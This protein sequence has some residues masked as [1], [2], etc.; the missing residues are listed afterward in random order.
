MANLFDFDFSAEN[1]AAATTTVTAAET[2]AAPGLSRMRVNNIREI[3]ATMPKREPAP[4]KPS[5]MQQ[6]IKTFQADSDDLA[7]A[8]AKKDEEIKEMLRAERV[9]E[10]RD[11][12]EAAYE[13][14]RLDDYFDLMDK[15]ERLEAG[16]DEEPAPEMAFPEPKKKPEPSL[17]P[18]EEPESD[19][20]MDFMAQEIVIGINKVSER[21]GQALSS[22]HAEKILRESW[23]TAEINFRESFKALY[24]NNQNEVIGIITV[25]MGGLTS[26]QV[27][28]KILFAGALKV[29]ATG[30]IVAHNHPSGTLHPSSDDKKITTKI[31]DA[32]KLLDI[33]ILDHMIITESKMFSFL[34][35]GLM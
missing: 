1:A 14:N 13:E 30:I 16:E 31:V 4:L 33:R 24:L 23:S 15:I 27:D 7:Q 12:A 2:A 34:D 26:C 19:A 3:L 8:A 25:G 18:D 32:G 11:L 17:Q 21:K 6:I 20:V 35:N 5:A 9:R 28:V 10:L 29:G 22:H